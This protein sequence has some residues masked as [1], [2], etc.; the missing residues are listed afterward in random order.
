MG[1]N[2]D[3]DTAKR[4]VGETG[5]DALAV[6][7]GNVHLLE[8]EK[9]CIDYGLLEKLK[10]SIPVPLVLHG[11]TGVSA[12]DLKKAIRMGI[13]KLNVGTVLKREYLNKVREY[14]NTKDINHIDPHIL[15]GW[16]GE[17]DMIS[18]GRAAIAAKT[19]EFIEILGSAGQADKAAAFHERN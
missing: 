12:E 15:I 16:G 2:T 6:S 11:G 4:F 18:C 5:I 7:I 13:S 10:S 14:L 3:V 9:A 19:M 17:E 1:Q 8:G